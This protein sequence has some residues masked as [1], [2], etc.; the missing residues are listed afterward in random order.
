VQDLT[1]AKNIQNVQEIVVHS[2]RKLLG[3]DGA[4]VVF[5]ENNQCFYAA[6]DAVAPLWEGQRFPIESC[7]SGWAMLNKKSL[8][9]D[10]IF[11][12]P[13]VPVENYRHT[14]VKSLT[15]V[16]INLN[17]PLGAIGNYWKTNYKPSDIEVALLQSLA[18]SAARAIENISL[19]NEIEHK[20]IERTKRLEASFLANMSHEIRT[21]INSIMGFSSLLP[22][23]DSK[24]LMCN[25]AN[26]IVRNSEHLVHIIDDIVLYSRLQAKMLAFH[27]MDFNLCN[28]F[29][30]LEHILSP[31]AKQKGIAFIFENTIECANKFIT[32]YEKL[33][34]V[35]TGLIANAIK[36]TEEGFVRV[37]A[38][39]KNE[40]YL[41]SVCDTG[42]GIPEAEKSHIFDRFFRGSNTR[43]ETVPGTGLGL[44]IV[45]ELLAILGGKIWFECNKGKGTCFYFTLPIAQK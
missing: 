22:E 15:M 45:R 5:K 1:A 44:S 21:P 10:D 36:Y 11:D 24:E 18:D 33:K 4:S 8:V 43:K 12:D 19:L 7:V 20:A 40:A 37:T 31:Q 25:Y 28:L 35:L 6:E 41:F 30:E 16:P 27:A 2:A 9:I 32:D 23:E 29:Q 39:N 26:I 34:Q 38:E 13:R 3:S 14:F 17:E 42:I